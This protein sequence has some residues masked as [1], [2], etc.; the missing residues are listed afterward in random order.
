MS[1]Y[2][3]RDYVE[4]A[5]A[6]KRLDR[7]PAAVFCSFIPVLPQL[8]I[9]T[10]E[11]RLEPDK[12][13]KAMA[14]TVELIPSDAMALIV[15]DEALIAE[16]PGKEVGLTRE[17]VI[18]QAR[19]GL[20]LLQDKALFARFKLPD[21]KEGQR[22]PYY[23]EFCRLATTHLREI[24]V[25]PFIP[26]P[27]S[28]AMGW[29]GVEEFIFDTQDDPDFTHQVLHF[30]TE[31]SKM[32]GEAL[33]DTGIGY[34]VIG[35]PSASCSVISPKMFREWV[36]PYLKETVD[37]LKGLQK[38]KVLLHMCGYAD[39][40]MEDLVSIGFDGIS[41]DSPSSLQRMVAVSQNQTVIIGNTSTEMFLSGTREEV[42]QAVKE[43]IAAAAAD[44][45]YILCS[46]CQVPD[47]APVENIRTYLE[48]AHQYGSY[49][50][51]LFTAS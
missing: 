39:P 12:F 4:A 22:L 44:N 40:L 11:I 8:G 31:Y 27:W 1:L 9:T 17:Q 25:F 15:G 37:Y 14:R 28:T 35:E 51:E 16:V 20:H 48:A 26:S 34:A 42:E 41:I 18:A 38:G 2:C 19:Q 3:G 46:G 36:Q 29:R 7:V 10:K 24:A 32:V 30:T 6:R 5:F 47:M 50:Q 43:D 13:I 33:L 21:L 49:D 23:L 45:G